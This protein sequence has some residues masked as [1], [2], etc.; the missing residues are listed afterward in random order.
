MSGTT[1]RALWL[2]ARAQLAALPRAEAERDA[3]LLIQ[4]A[5][6]LTPAGFTADL[7]RT[8]AADDP[9][10]RHLDWMLTKRAQRMP[11]SHILGEAPFWGRTFEVTRAT[12]APRG[13]TE[14][15]M[16]EA[17]TVGFDRLLDLGT[18]TGCLAVSLLAE[19]QS[20]RC[21]ATDISGAALDVAR[22]NAARHGVEARLDLIQSDWLAEVSGPFD[23]IVSNPPYI[24]ADAYATLAPEV[25]AHE[26]EI[27]LTPGGDGLQPY[28]ILCAQTPD[29][30]TPGGWLMVEVGYDQGA[31]V[32][33][34]MAG[35]G[36][37]RVARVADM[38]GHDRV[39]RGQ[40]APLGL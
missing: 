28:R 14:T 8:I 2:S 40:R 20:A 30:I 5:F 34:L 4:A 23:L 25:R 9:C 1:L 38:S 10:L 19:R 3:R 37:Q 11:V 6:R 29:R 17:L 13:D 33:A 16:A 7:G 15:L 36:F 32:A 18:G 31:S 39:V 22:R 21:V 12:L 27:A 35:A 26:P 24:T